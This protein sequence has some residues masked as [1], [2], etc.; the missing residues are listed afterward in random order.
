[1]W[2][3]LGYSGNKVYVDFFFRVDSLV[4]FGF[5]VGCIIVGVGGEFVFGYYWLGGVMDS[6]VEV[7]RD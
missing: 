6:I 7:R 3:I 1:M 4:V 2:Y 5:C